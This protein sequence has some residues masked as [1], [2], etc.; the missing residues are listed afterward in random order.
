MYLKL[1]NIMS[2]NPNKA[3][4]VAQENLNKIG[5]NVEIIRETQSVKGLNQLLWK[6]SQLYPDVKDDKVAFEL[7]EK[8]DN[9]YSNHISAGT[10]SNPKNRKN[11]MG[12]V[13]FDINPNKPL[14]NI[15][16]G[17][18]TYNVQSAIQSFQDD[19]TKMYVNLP[20]NIKSD[21]NIQES[22]LSTAKLLENNFNSVNR[23]GDFYIKQT[24][25]PLI[26]QFILAHEL[27]HISFKEKYDIQFK[28]V[29]KMQVPANS[30]SQKYLSN[31]LLN[32]NR[33]LDSQ[34]MQHEGANYSS[35]RDEIH[36]DVAGMFTVA[37]LGLKKGTTTEADLVRFFTQMGKL[38]ENMNEGESPHRFGSHNSGLL[39]TT[40]NINKVINLAKQ[41]IKNPNMDSYSEVL[42]MTEDIFFDTIKRNGIILKRPLELDT[43]TVNAINSGKSGLNSIT[44][45][46]N[47]MLN[48]NKV[49][50]DTYKD[51]LNDYQNTAHNHSCLYYLNGAQ[52]RVV[53]T[54]WDKRIDIK[55]LDDALKRGVSSGILGGV[56]Q[57]T[58]ENIEKQVSSIEANELTKFAELNNIH[59]RMT[60]QFGADIVELN[61]TGA[62]VKFK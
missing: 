2:S 57:S 25:E 33:Y 30:Q 22:F 47:S 8:K 48:A 29:D 19:I 45:Y 28:Y 51:C 36:S 3:N 35:T 60:N 46:E 53:D 6:P 24:D 55:N 50:R 41:N 26:L 49:S 32:L 12:L 5:K 20:Q 4:S 56:N 14:L 34:G 52:K 43:P 42:N 61:R 59:M 16:D 31:A 9:Q 37:Y 62:T 11:L 7:T 23:R 54:N 40:E 13:D 1:V 17:A 38:R 21:K 18:R 10:I 58:P 15:L 27:A 44:A 39:F